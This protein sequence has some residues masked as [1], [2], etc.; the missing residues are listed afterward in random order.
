METKV[1]QHRAS[2]YR[3]KPCT[4]KLIDTGLPNPMTAEIG[5]A[6]EANRP[7]NEPSYFQDANLPWQSGKML[8]K[9]QKT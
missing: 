1:L 6:S 9:Y 4:R 5:R 7:H 2:A 3:E 8:D